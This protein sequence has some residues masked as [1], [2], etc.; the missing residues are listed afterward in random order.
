[1]LK[2]KLNIDERDNTIIQM[3]QKNPETSQEEIAKVLKLSQ[4]SVW[5]RIRNLK[6]DGIIKNIVG[7]NFKDVNLNLAKVEV[8]ATDTKS[9]IEEFKDCPYFLNAL[10]M[11]GKFNVCLFFAGTD[12]K[13]IEGIVNH[14][15]RSNPKVKDVEMNFVVTTIKDFVMPLNIDDTNKNQ[16]KCKQG[17]K[18][19]LE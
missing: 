2:E 8:S 18:H 5:A 10:I 14:H 7:L 11:S 6:R 4:P 17:C 19:S 3:L 1:M 9:V 12:L 16:L 13:N 15:L